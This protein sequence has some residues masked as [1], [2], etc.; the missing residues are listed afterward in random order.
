MK[1]YPWIKQIKFDRRGLVPA[2]IQD[3][4][5]GKVLMAAYMNHQA[6]A[7]TIASGKVHFW[8]RSRR[9]LWM[10][11]ESSG[12]TQSVRAVFID[13]DGDTLLLKVKPAGAA[14][15]TGYYTCFYRRLD[16]QSKRLNI[17]G[18]QAFDPKKVYRKVQL[19]SVK[20]S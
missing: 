17:V 1:A 7:K 11:G 13:C 2:I 19:M 8:S 16:P 15:H 3:A 20:A 9:K 12:H 5:T 18:K 10:K 6:L 14:C 4:Q